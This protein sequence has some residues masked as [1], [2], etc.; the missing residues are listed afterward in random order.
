MFNKKKN[1]EEAVVTEKAPKTAKQSIKNTIALKRNVYA[2][3]LSVIFIL[4]VV[5]VNAFSTVM[6]ARYP[7]ELDLTS[8]KKHSISEDNIDFIRSIEK[9]VTIYVCLTEEQYNCTESDNMA[10]VAA[11]QYFVDYNSSNMQYFVQSAELLEKI[12]RY[13]DNIELVYLDM[14]QPESALITADFEDFDFKTGD[15]LLQCVNGKNEKGEDTYRRTA[16]LFEDIYTTEA[17]AYTQTAIQYSALYGNMALWGQGAGYAITENNMEKAVSSAIYKVISETT[18]KYLVPTTYYTANDDG[19][20]VIDKYLKDLLNVNNYELDYSEGAIVNLIKDKHDE[21]EGIILAGCKTDISDADYEAIL[22]FLDN[23]GKKGKSLFYFAGID[24][25]NKMPRLCALMAEWGIGYLDG[26]VYETA[27]SNRVVKD[28]KTD[29]KA[30]YHASTSTDHTA[31]ADTKGYYIVSNTVPMKVLYPKNVTATYARSTEVLIRTGGYGTTTIMPVGAD[32]ATWKP[33]DDGAEVTYDAYP[34][35]IMS[36]DETTLEDHSFASSYVV[37]FA[38]EE[39]IYNEW[40]TE[41]TNVANDHMTLDIFNSVSGLSESP[42]NFVAKTITEERFYA[43]E[44]AK[45]TVQIIFMAI[46]PV[47]IVALGITVWV[48]RKRK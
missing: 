45:L 32:A 37:A 30:F 25:V 16:V 48:V 42:F 10:Q 27:S 6:A 26:I 43:T 20:I 28:E 7:L 17:S 34:T 36:K 23:S 47:A 9:D 21:Y 31:R 2:V 29:P 41:W 35:V 33:G 38:T 12:A 11:N 44:N 18:P 13:N 1:T 40:I 22:S 24:V 4:A 39:Y 46:V 14:N 3:V 19:T 15:L 8:D 5:L